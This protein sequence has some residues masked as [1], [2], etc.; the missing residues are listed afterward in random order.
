MFKT[1]MMG[2]IALV[3]GRFGFEHLYFSID[4][5]FGFRILNFSPQDGLTFA[6]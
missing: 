4:S 2:S 5:D 3:F 1:N 6:L